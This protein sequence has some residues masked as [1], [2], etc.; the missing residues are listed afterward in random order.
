MASV[1]TFLIGSTWRTRARF[2]NASGT[3]TAPTTVTCKIRDPAGVETSYTL[4][5]G[6]VTQDAVGN[7]YKDFV[8]VLAGI[9]Y[10]RWIGTGTVADAQ[11]FRLEVPP[12]N[13]V[14]P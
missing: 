13:F 5:G 12:S 7:Y 9:H 11:E 6:T 4:A 3:L 1:A 8:I 10:A 14:T 2:S